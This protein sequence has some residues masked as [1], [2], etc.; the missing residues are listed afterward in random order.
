MNRPKNGMRLM[1]GVLAGIAIGTVLVVP[2]GAHIGKPVHLWNKH[3]LK[4]AVKSFYTKAEADARFLTPAA[5]D[6]Q[7][8]TPTEGDARYSQV[9]YAELLGTMVVAANSKN[10]AQGNVSNPEPGIFCFSG[11][12]F[13]PRS[14][15]ATFMAFGGVIQTRLADG[16]TSACTGA[17]AEVLTTNSGGFFANVSFMI[18]LHS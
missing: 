16:L 10:I 8:L 3:L 12:P 18:L 17:Q 13:T 6:A 1:A 5:A 15:V 14:A 9:A 2:A 4:L 7:F 11:L